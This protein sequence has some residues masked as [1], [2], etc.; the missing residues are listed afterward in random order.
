[1]KLKIRKTAKVLI[2]IVTWNSHFFMENCL[3]SVFAQTYKDFSVLIIDNASTDK[4]IEFIRKKYSSF[5][6]LFILKNVQNLGFAPAHNQ[7]FN[8]SQSDFIL[9]MNPDIVLQPDF[10]EKLMTTMKTNRRIGSCSG[11]L[12]KMKFNNSETKVKGI[13]TEIIDSTGLLIR[14]SGQAIDRGEGEEDRGQYDKV[15]DVFGLSGA[16]VLYRRKALE[17]VKIPASKGYEYFD[18]DFF[19]YKEDVDLAWRLNLRNWRN[20]YVSGAMAYHFRAGAP[21]SKRFCQSP[22]INFY[23]FRNHLWMLIKDIH[24][25]IFW[26]NIGRIFLYLSLKK[27][28][29]FFTQPRILFQSGFSFWK[30]FFKMIHKRRYIMRKAKARPEKINKWFV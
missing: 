15:N 12:L 5:E 23:S 14:K 29:L 7:G 26:K 30:K 22:L 17:D 2:Q 9:V 4:T 1:M 19:A 16:C 10:L 3:D 28:Y 11:K 27:T 24:S 21:K 18:N 25:P 8:I 20:V 13:K 6:N